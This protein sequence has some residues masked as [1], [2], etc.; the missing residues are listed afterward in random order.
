MPPNRQGPWYL[1]NRPPLSVL[2]PMALDLPSSLPCHTSVLPA[3]PHCP[4]CVYHLPT[5][6]PSLAVSPTFM[7][8][9]TNSCSCLPPS[10]TPPSHT[11]PLLCAPSTPGTTHTVPQLYHSPRLHTARVPTSNPHGSLDPRSYSTHPHVYTAPLFLTH[12]HA[13]SSSVPASIIP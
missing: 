1:Y 5:S 7:P 3:H 10:S 8:Y 2:L 12:S 11:A 6:T 13:Q 9:N 4:Q